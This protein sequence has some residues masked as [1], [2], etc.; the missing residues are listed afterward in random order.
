MCEVSVRVDERVRLV[1]AVL[2]AGDWPALEQNK[3]GAHAVHPQAKAIRRFLVQYADHPA[4]LAANR[5]LADGVAP[6][7]LFTVAVR[8]DWPDFRPQVSLPARMIGWAEQLAELQAEI[9]VTARF[10]SEH[11]V[12]WSEAVADLQGI[13]AGTDLPDFLEQLLRRT[14]ATAIVIVPN[15]IYPAMETVPVAAEGSY[16]LL[17]PPPKAVGESPPWPYRDEEEG[18]LATACYHSL[19]LALAE[20]L[21]ALSPAHEIRFRHAATVLFLERAVDETAARFYLLRRRK[22]AGI[23]GLPE[24]VATLRLFLNGEEDTLSLDLM[25]ARLSN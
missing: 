12:I 9:E 7:E 6:A 5:Y 23:E 3:R 4:V 25:L 19:S 21:A 8:C 13:F 1:A 15:L 17:I 14:L 11:E 10:W 2:A 18:V 16:Y 20:P 24:A 22:E